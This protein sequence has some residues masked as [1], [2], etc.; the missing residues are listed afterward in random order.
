[1]GE[2]EELVGISLSG[3]E[4]E[5][6]I[7]RVGI[8]AQFLALL[9]KISIG[10]DLTAQPLAV[11][12]GFDDRDTALERFQS[13]SLQHSDLLIE[14]NSLEDPA[15]RL[16]QVV[17]WIFTLGQLFYSRKPLNPVLGEVSICKFYSNTNGKKEESTNEKDTS[18]KEKD[19]STNKEKEKEIGEKNGSK[20]TNENN[21]EKN[22]R[23]ESGKNEAECESEKNAVEDG[24]GKDTIKESEKNENE[25]KEYQTEKK[26]KD[27][28]YSIAEQVSHH[29]PISTYVTENEER[30]IRIAGYSKANI[31]FTGTAIKLV[32][33]GIQTVSYA[34]FNNETYSYKSPPIFVRLIGLVLEYVGDT[35]ITCDSSPFVARIS[36]KEKPFLRGQYHYLKGEIVKVEKRNQND[37]ITSNDRKD[38]VEKE[39]KGEKEEIREK[40]EKGEKMG[41][42]Y[43]VDKEDKEERKEE[44]IMRFKGHW[45][46]EV[47][48]EDLRNGKK[49][50]FD[51]RDYPIKGGTP[52][53]PPLEKEINESARKIWHFLKTAPDS[54][55]A[56]K[57]K[58]EVEEEQRRKVKERAA[59]GEIHKFKFFEEDS[60]NPL[61]YKLKPGSLQSIL[62]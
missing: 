37:E 21:D 58:R 20:E 60:E 53:Y 9:R 55:A 26:E 4:K 18:E 14:T 38:E 27:V 61:L 32:F 49:F 46:Q 10:T 13:V 12:A 40:A 42:V 50:T 28:F 59:K 56:A 7:E 44:V 41:K 31:K 3:G 47:Q 24:S 54:T 23:D 43:K 52:V 30:G 39:E 33:D 29:P 35:E 19:G 22:E 8:I 5:S 48:F 45:D 6:T 51:G 2:Q 34:K 16:V 57:A 17:K 15:M 1:M 36:Y 62:F 11:P 25:E